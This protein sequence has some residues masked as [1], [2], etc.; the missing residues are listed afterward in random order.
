MYGEYFSGLY[1]QNWHYNYAYNTLLKNEKNRQ[2]LKRYLSEIRINV[3]E[4]LTYVSL[5]A[6]RKVYKEIKDCIEN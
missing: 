1:Q 4:I 6:K 2:L 5:A 3:Q